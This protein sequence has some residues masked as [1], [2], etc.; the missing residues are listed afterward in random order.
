MA[1][2]SRSIRAVTRNFQ[3]LSELYEYNYRMAPTK[4]TRKSGQRNP[5]L[6]MDK[7]IESVIEEVEEAGID[8]E[9]A[10]DDS[11]PTSARVSAS[12]NLSRTRRQQFA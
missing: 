5:S 2:Y 6:R 7:F 10:V 9:H 3:N 11:E 8:D 12:V 4:K 1:D